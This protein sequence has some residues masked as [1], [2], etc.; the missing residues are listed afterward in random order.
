MAYVSFVVSSLLST[1]RERCVEGYLEDWFTEDEIKEFGLLEMP[2]YELEDF[3]TD[4][5]FG[6]DLEWPD[7][8]PLIKSVSN[9]YASIMDNECDEVEEVV[10]ESYDPEE[11]M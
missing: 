10:V 7:E 1:K 11:E 2:D 5:L 9:T 3:L 8:D 6:A 4:R